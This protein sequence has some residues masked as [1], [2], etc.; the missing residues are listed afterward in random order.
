MAPDE[1]MVTLTKRGVRLVPAGPGLIAKPASKL[2]DADRQAIHTCKAGLLRLLLLDRIETAWKPGEWLA[3]RDGRQLLTA[4]YAGTS[5]EGTVNV[6]LANGTVEA[7]AAE[8]V[9]LDW[10]PDAAEIFEE[11]LSIMLEA[12]IREDVA[13][14][15]SEECTREYSRRIEAAGGCSERFRPVAME[16]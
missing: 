13:P 8:A 10:C 15:R 6:W 3:H 7:I 4:K 5:T 14:Q 16:R 11:R 9:A 2:T 1:I 12:G